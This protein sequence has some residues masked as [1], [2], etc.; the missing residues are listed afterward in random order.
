MQH[1][2]WTMSVR[3]QTPAGNVVHTRLDADGHPGYLS[4]SRR[5]C[6]TFP[7]GVWPR[8]LIVQ[9]QCCMRSSSGPNPDAGPIAPSTRATGWRTDGPD[10]ANARIPYW[11]ADNIPATAQRSGRVAAE[12]PNAMPSR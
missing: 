3:G 12:P 5:V 7:A 9:C 6:T 8:T 4:A 10:R 2:H 1:G 11:L